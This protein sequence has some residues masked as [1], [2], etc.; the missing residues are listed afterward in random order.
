MANYVLKGRLTAQ[1]SALIVSLSV[2]LAFM[3]AAALAQSAAPTAAEITATAQV[4]GKY[5]QAVATRV[6]AANK[7]HASK[8]PYRTVSVVGYTVLKSGEVTQTWIVRSS[9]EPKT[10]NTALESFK[11]GLPL[12]LPDTAMFGT[13]EEVSLSEAFVFSADS[14]WRLQSL[15][16]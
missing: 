9:G 6:N 4:I 16:K 12:P 11:R 2:T 15:I 3:P 14:S 5:K 8:S 7:Q 10:D 1:V 13:D